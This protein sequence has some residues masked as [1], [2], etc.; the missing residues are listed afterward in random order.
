MEE[1]YKPIRA[2]DLV[3]KTDGEIRVTTKEESQLDR[4]EKKLDSILERLEDKE[5]S[6]SDYLTLE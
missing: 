5:L 1:K 3:F 6:S 4:I 2:N